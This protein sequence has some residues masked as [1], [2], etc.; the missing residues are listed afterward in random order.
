MPQK[1]KDLT[2]EPKDIRAASAGEAEGCSERKESDE[3]HAPQMHKPRLTLSRW[4]CQLWKTRIPVQKERWFQQLASPSLKTN[5]R[6]RFARIAM[7]R[8]S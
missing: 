8:T 2:R 6:R 1:P 4:P 7:R 5:T 3:V